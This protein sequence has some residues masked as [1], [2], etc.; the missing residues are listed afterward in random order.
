MILVCSRFVVNLDNYTQSVEVE[1][2]DYGTSSGLQSPDSFGDCLYSGSV[3]NSPEL[4]DCKQVRLKTS[5]NFTFMEFYKVYTE[6][7]LLS[8]SDHGQLEVDRY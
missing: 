8:L 2:C 7:K 6:H 1:E 5:T 3:G 4:T